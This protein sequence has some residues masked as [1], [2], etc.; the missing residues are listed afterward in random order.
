[1]SFPGSVMFT[2]RTATVTI[3]APDAS[4]AR[5]VS[6]NERYFPVPTMRREWYSRPA[7]TKGSVICS[8]APDEVDHLDGV[9]FA[10]RRA[11]VC[12]ARNDRTVHLDG[13]APR[14]EAERGH[15]VGHGRAVG[16]RPGFVVHHHRHR[17]RDDIVPS[18]A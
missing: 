18:R 16:Q 5:R 3:S 10:Q 1:F 14:A 8:T 12:D 7:R 11:L 17:T 15:Q 2:R 6:S 4:T 13:D 9:A